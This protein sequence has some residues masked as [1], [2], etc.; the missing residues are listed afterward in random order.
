[1]R[2]EQ[3][4][5]ESGQ[6]TVRI[7]VA[8]P[9]LPFSIFVHGAGFNGNAERETLGPKLSRLN[10]IW[11]DLL[12]APGAPTLEPER[13]SWANQIRD[14]V[15]VTRHFTEKPVNVIGHCQGASITHDL[16]R[17]APGFVRKAVWYSPVHTLGGALK[18]VISQATSQGRLRPDTM[19]DDERIWLKRFMQRGPEASEASDALFVLALSAKIRDLQELYWTDARAMQAWAEHANL[20]PFAAEAFLRLQSDFFAERRDLLPIPDYSGIPVLMLHAPEDFICPWQTNGK[21]LTQSIPHAIDREIRGGAHWLQF[22]KPD[23]CAAL[24]VNFLA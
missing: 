9:R 13:L 15:T 5:T 4:R 12:G 24:T 21:R 18:N 11:F 6:Y 10:M 2:Q 20:Y 19:T 7:N 23:E 8:D 17:T 22:Q 14:I 1:M 3:F 16:L